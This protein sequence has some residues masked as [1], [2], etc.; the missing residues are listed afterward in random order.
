MS[1]QQAGTQT[2]RAFL[3]TM[4][5]GSLLAASGSAEAETT[6]IK[7]G[8]E[9]DGWKGEQPSSISGKTNPT[10][11]L[12][13]GQK[14]KVV[15]KNLDGQQHNFEILDTS[16]KAI[17]S[18]KLISS[19]GETA[20]VEFTATKEMQKYNCKIHPTTMK[21]GIQIAGGEKKGGSA[22]SNLPTGAYIFAAA[23]L[24]AVLSPLLFALLLMRV[25]TG[26]RVQPSR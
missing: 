12:K 4:A 8:G 17:V 25:G 1:E 6:T 16:G 10:L 24:I 9:I 11:K 14:Y 3:T 19:K 18:T 7:L 21:G 5:A 23:I 26:D 20:E 15:W 2:R 22:G 13:P